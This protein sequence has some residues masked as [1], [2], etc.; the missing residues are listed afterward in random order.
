MFLRGKIFKSRIADAQLQLRDIEAK[1]LNHKKR[2]KKQH[3]RPGQQHL[4]TGFLIQRTWEA[5]VLNQKKQH[6][7]GSSIIGPHT[8][9]RF[10]E[11]SNFQI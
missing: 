10:F 8:G 6:A 1:G 4:T 2:I 7:T 11:G 9:L 3:I 5:Q